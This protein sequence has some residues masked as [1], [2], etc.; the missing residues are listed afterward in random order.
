MNNTPSKDLRYALYIRKSSEGEDKQAQSPETQLREMTEYAERNGIKILRI[1]EDHASAF[2][3]NN[4]PQFNELLKAIRKKEINAVLTWDA[5]RLARN[6]KEAGVLCDL[7]Q[8]G[9]IELIETYSAIY[10]PKSNMLIL[11]IKLGMSN[12]YSVDLSHRVKDG[13]KTKILNGGYTSYAPLGYRNNKEEKTVEPDPERFNTLQKLIKLYYRGDHSMKSICKIAKEMGFKTRKAKNKPE[14]DL[15]IP[16]LYR[17]LKNPF[18]M[19]YVSLEGKFIKGNHKPMITK[20]QFETIQSH[21]QRQKTT[22]VMTKYEIPFRN[23][24]TCG[25]CG[26]GITAHKKLKY[27]CPNCKQGHSA[28][29]PKICACGYEIQQ[30]DIGTARVYYY[31]HCTT[32]SKCSQPHVRKEDINDQFLNYINRLQ[33]NSEFAEW[34]MRWIKVIRNQQTETNSE[35]K[36]NLK[37]AISKIEDKEDRLLELRMDG[38]LDKDE[39]LKKK[40]SYSSEIKRLETELEKLSRDNFNTVADYLDFLS[41]LKEVFE[42][43]SDS[44]KNKIVNR[45]VLNPVLFAKTIDLTS[46]KPYLHITSLERLHR[47][48]IEPLENALSKPLSQSQNGVIFHVVGLMRCCL[49][50]KFLY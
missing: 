10:T 19:G 33:I 27:Y 34:I 6:Y 15:S 1:F 2:K 17:A 35:T 24:M 14:K 43:G 18:Y 50:L 16:T 7:L 30:S 40:E 48:G 44:I 28:K 39:F 20:N 11:A 47:G 3:Y 32:G 37:R 9:V 22:P 29:K 25:E 4:R 36:A 49:N 21:L 23:L 42:N 8:R 45:I 26:C 41:G 38:E 5:D 12:Q 46:Q 13:N 31:Y